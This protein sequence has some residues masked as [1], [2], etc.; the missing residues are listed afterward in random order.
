[1]VLPVAVAV[2]MALVAS[3]S[4][5]K[6]TYHEL[7]SPGLADFGMT[8]SVVKADITTSV[9]MSV[10]MSLAITVVRPALLFMSP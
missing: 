9:A 6:V 3:C 8:L 2:A 4:D 5:L 7:E 1:M 10:G